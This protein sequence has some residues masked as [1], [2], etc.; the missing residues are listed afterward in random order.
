MGFSVSVISDILKFPSPLY[1]KYKNSMPLGLR[2]DIPPLAQDFIFQIELP[3]NKYELK[4]L[5]FSSTGY[6]DGDKYSLTVDDKYVLNGI[7]TKELG[8][9][10]D[11]QPIVKITSPTNTLKFVYH[12]TTG[13]SKVIWIDLL[14]TCQSV[15][16]ATGGTAYQVVLK[17][18]SPL[19]Y[20][21]AGNG[22]DGYLN[23]TNIDTTYWHQPMNVNNIAVRAPFWQG[24]NDLLTAYQSTASVISSL[25]DFHTY[26]FYLT[27]ERV[28]GFEDPVFNNTWSNFRDKARQ[29]Y[30]Q[31]NG[32]SLS[33]LSDRQ[34]AEI[35]LSYH[36]KTPVTIFDSFANIV[37]GTLLDLVTTYIDM[38]RMFVYD[39]VDFN[40]V[41]Q[42]DPGTVTAGFTY[43]P[44]G[45][46]TDPNVY[47]PLSY[48]KSYINL[49]PQALM[50]PA[51]YCDKTHPREYIL[52]STASNWTQA[53]FHANDGESD[54]FQ[55]YDLNVTDNGISVIATF[56]HEM[57]HAIDF[58]QRDKN[59]NLFSNQSNWLSISGWDPDYFSKY[60]YGSSPFLQVPV[61]KSQLP[62]DHIEPPITPYG[63]SHPLEDFAESYAY[64]IINPT[65]LQHEYPKRYAFM[66]TYIK[67][68]T[69]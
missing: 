52:P 4:G 5:V 32:L 23:P 34:L 42:D 11:L 54:P 37:N 59:G 19:A 3:T 47:G 6:K 68:F 63:C 9:Q 12:N 7:Y 25:T 24:R 22:E 45:S 21:V 1:P 44:A 8:Q 17:D 31:Y 18:I 58:Y 10:I 56:V 41:A 69:G 26:L 13:T 35:Y 28:N 50:I 67:T 62:D 53:H 66:E 39:W 29:D 61:Y 27:K 16:Y 65:F 30:V 55:E 15:V 38:A 14:L 48:I 33:S 43:D 57:G 40:D 60:E 46:S 64:Y 36:F 51:S 20:F 49:E 2:Y